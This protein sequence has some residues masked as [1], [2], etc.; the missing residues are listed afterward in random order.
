MRISSAYIAQMFVA[1]QD[2]QQAALA[3][4]QQQISSGQSFSTPAENPSAAT[5]VL[6]LQSTL[7]QLSQYSTN[8]NL[9]QSRLSI[10]D[11][12]LSSVV[13][14]LQSIRSLALEA[15]SGTTD[16][17]TRASLATQIQSESQSLLQLANTQDGNGQYIFAGTATTTTPFSQSGS[18]V[19]YAGNQAQRLVQIAPGVTI[20]DGDSGAALFQQIRNGNGTFVVG[21][22]AAN[23]GTGIIGANSVT[24]LASW[25]S[26]SPPYTIKFTSPTAY[27][28]TNSAGATVQSGTYTDGNAI[29]FAGAQLTISGTPAAGD[30]FTVAKSQN[31]DVFA[32]ISKL[33]TALNPPTAGSEPATADTINRAIE[34]L[35]QTQNNVSVIQSQ[36][37]SRLQAIDA[38]NSTN[39]SMTLQLKSNVS[40]LQDLDYAAAATTLQQQMTALQAAQ[41]SFSRIS[42]LSLFNY[43]Q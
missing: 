1:S 17:A 2:A 11:T 25:N 15:Q 20:A 33:V 21:A 12:T 30:T 43:I 22:N 35:D 37:G 31:Q 27:T 23:T 42:G 34:A 41:A 8:A 32:T 19:T 4:T 7:S 3:Q 18:S 24:S 40:S 38:Q 14:T 39:S 16:S 6:G 26:G 13:S 29:S 5:Q 9:A 36:V 10:E 28:V